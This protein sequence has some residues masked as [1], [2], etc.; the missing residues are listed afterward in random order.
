M[1]TTLLKSLIRS[2]RKN[3]KENSRNKEFTINI[4]LLM[5]WLPMLSRVTEDS[6]GPAKTMMVMS[7]VMSSLK[8][9]VH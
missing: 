9:M 6:F 3:S 5:T 2:I 8:V 4:D 7:K 1:I